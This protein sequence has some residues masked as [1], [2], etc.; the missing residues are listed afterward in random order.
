[1]YIYTMKWHEMTKEMGRLIL[2]TSFLYCLIYPQVFA[3][4]YHKLLVFQG[5]DDFCEAIHILLDKVDLLLFTKQFRVNLHP[6]FPAK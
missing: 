5:W 4:V 3:E 2:S 1:M 6:C